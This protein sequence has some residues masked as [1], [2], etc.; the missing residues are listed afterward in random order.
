M[1]EPVL[2]YVCDWPWNT[3]GNHNSKP[4]NRLSSYIPHRK[5]LA[6]TLNEMD[7]YFKILIIGQIYIGLQVLRFSP[8]DVQ[9]TV[10]QSKELRQTKQIKIGQ[11]YYLHRMF[12]FWCLSFLSLE[13]AQPGAYKI[14]QWKQQLCSFPIQISPLTVTLFTVTPRLQWHSWHVPNDWFITELPLVSV[15]IWLQWHFS[16]VP[17]VS[18]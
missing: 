6:S 17:R 2:K 8:L 14:W 16:H 9:A 18:L 7:T 13:I 15:T 10:F 1:L 12:F 5:R 3:V 11:L 4:C